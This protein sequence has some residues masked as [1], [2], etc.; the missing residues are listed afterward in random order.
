MAYIPLSPKVIEKWQKEN[1]ELH[2]RCITT[3]LIQCSYRVN[4]RNK[5]FALYDRY[6]TP[7][8]ILCYFNKPIRIFVKALVQDKLDEIGDIYPQ[9]KPKK[10]TRKSNKIK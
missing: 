5:F 10:R 3:Y 9:K 7:G 4:T 8:N 6:I 2:K 1:I